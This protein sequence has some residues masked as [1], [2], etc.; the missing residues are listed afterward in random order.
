MCMYQA[1]F[2]GLG[3][4]KSH[5]KNKQNDKQN[6]IPVTMAEANEAIPFTQRYVSWQKHNQ[7][8]SDVELE[9]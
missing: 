8:T 4:T 7:F 9:S 3:K 6:K 2:V 5:A 1:G